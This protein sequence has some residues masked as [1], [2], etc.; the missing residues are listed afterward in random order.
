MFI[1]IEGIEGSG[2]ST[3]ANGLS[4]KIKESF[5]KEVVLTREPGAS[6]L[7]KKL[8]EILLRRE[9][10]DTVQIA[11]L[12]LFGADRAQHIHEVIRPSINK[13][14][15]VIS[16]RYVHSTLSYQ[17]YGRGIPL[18]TLESINDIATGGLLPSLVILLDLE[19][20]TGLA[21]AKSRGEDS[22]T[23]F[24]EEEISFHEKIRN[25]FLNLAKEQKDIFFVLDAKNPPETLIE[26]A[27]KEVSKRY[28]GKSNV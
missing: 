7:G 8:R 24:E 9:T 1:T 20:K 13:G 28:K 10:F 2:K 15:F 17:G 14:H 26:N 22:W 18:E 21:R 11:E 5:D 6:A 27:F 12:L 23:S 4:Q 19:V 3:L 25:G 16:D